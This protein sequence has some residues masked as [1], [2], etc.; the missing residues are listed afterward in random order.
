MVSGFATVAGSVMATYVRFGIDAGHILSASVMSA[1]AAVVVAKIMF[2]ETDNPTTMDGAKIHTDK[3]TV[4]VIDAAATGAIQGLKIA[5]IVGAMLIAFLSLIAMINYI[6][7][8]VGT[9]LGG[10]FGY[11]FAPIAFCMGVDS[12]DMLEVG[13]LLGTKIAVNEFVGYL[14]LVS[15]KDQ[16]SPRSFLISTYA[17]C[18]FASFGSVAIAIGGIGQIAPS[19]RGD[20]A[21]IGLK[22]MVGGALAS[23]L[24]ASIAGMML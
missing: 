1:P 20:I 22:A 6:F 18:G 10:I 12:A 15:L 8:F 13:R 7:S 17:L 2:P 16:I 14:D 4:N 23:W 9:S 24:T 21:R 5:A 3:E 11:I 19:R